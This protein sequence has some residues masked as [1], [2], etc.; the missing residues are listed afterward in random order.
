MA[1]RPH[2]VAQWRDGITDDFVGIG[3]WNRWQGKRLA[4]ARAALI[5]GV[6]AGGAPFT[7]DE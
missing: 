2:G 3:Q 6:V 5:E 7:L 1:E 4:V